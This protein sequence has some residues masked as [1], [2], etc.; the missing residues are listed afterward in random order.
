M[1]SLV[2]LAT[3]SIA[4]TTASGVGTKMTSGRRVGAAV[5]AD[6][7]VTPTSPATTRVRADARK[8]LRMRSNLLKIRRPTVY[9]TTHPSPA[10]RA[11]T[12]GRGG[13]GGPSD[14]SPPGTAAAPAAATRAGARY[15]DTWREPRARGRIRLRIWTRARPGRPSARLPGSQGR[16]G[17]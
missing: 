17:Y 16:G 7:L 2:T 9:D 12:D 3:C 8:R 13:A 5:C 14:S 1:S 10:R 4:S 11:R 15:L 6:A